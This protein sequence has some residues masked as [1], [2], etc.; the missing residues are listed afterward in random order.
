MRILH[1]SDWHIGKRLGRH[2]RMAEFHEVLGE[3]VSIADERAVDL[4]LV[5]GDVW[6]RPIPPMD[7]LTLGLET[8][9]RLAEGRPVIAVAG[10]HD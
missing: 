8:L 3:V 6:D 5:S 9:V 2:D 4:V 10:N 1:T 7:A